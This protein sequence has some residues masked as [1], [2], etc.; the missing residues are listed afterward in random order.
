MQLIGTKNCKVFVNHVELIAKLL[1][2]EYTYTPR[3][4][5]KR[6]KERWS[7][8]TLRIDL[9]HCEIENHDK[10]M[11]HQ[12]QQINLIRMHAKNRWTKLKFLFLI[13]HFSCDAHVSFS[14]C[15]LFG[16]VFFYFVFALMWSSI[17][18]RSIRYAYRRVM[19]CV[20]IGK[21][22]TFIRSFVRC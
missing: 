3:E 1:Q 19:I 6:E 4:S 12:Q 11:K 17:T 7:A 22:R 18:A 10:Y 16:C 21:V 2:V 8:L 20:S 15:C 13:V 9:L 5:T 14:C